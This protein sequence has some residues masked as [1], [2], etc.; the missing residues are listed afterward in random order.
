[1]E[2]A[3]ESAYQFFVCRSFD[4]R[5]GHSDA[6][7]TIML[8]CHTATRGARHDAHFKGDCAISFLTFNQLSIPFNGQLAYQR[9]SNHPL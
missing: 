5:R 4:R 7:R 9:R 2:R 1:M 3:G 8:S 6:Q